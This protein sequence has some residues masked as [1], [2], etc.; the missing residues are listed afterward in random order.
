MARVRWHPKA[1]EDLHNLDRWRTSVSLPPI[2]DYLLF[3]VTNYFRRQSPKKCVPGRP[4]LIK[5]EAVDLR[6]A[7]VQ[8]GRRTEPYKIFF[9]V[10]DN[11]FEVRRIRHPRQAD[12]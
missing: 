8:V 2:G 6:I 3:H 12:I 5:G 11:A 9:R 4:V 10:T 1:V 7:L